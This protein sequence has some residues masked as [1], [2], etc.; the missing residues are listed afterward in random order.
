MVRETVRVADLVRRAADAAAGREVTT[1]DPAVIGLTMDVDKR[2]LER[3]V[4]NLVGNAE[5][6]GGGCTG[7]RVERGPHGL[8]V[9]VDD[10]GPGI[11]PDRRSRVFER[12]ARGGSNERTGVGLG[13]AIVQRHVALHEGHV[14]VEEIPGGGA[15]FVVELPTTAT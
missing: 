10:A 2:R 6:H 12:F 4:A 13:L 11:A 8:R 14:F 5:T 3:V 1:V 15:R 7:V 9:V